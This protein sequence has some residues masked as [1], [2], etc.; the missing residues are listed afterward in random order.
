MKNNRG[1][2]LIELLVAFFAFSVIALAMSTTAVS[3]IKA[4]RRAFA[5]Q[6][7]QEDSRYII[8]TMGKE[9]R[10]GLV[11]SL[12]G[13]GVSSINITNSDGES[14]DYRFVFNKLQ[15]RVDGGIWQ[16]LNSTD[17]FHLNGSFYITKGV[18]PVRAI[19]TIAIK[20]DCQSVKAEEQATIYLQ[21]TIAPRI[22]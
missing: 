17:Y 16:D 18:S 7:I 19:V 3:T 10:M 20:L 6:S 1:F 12:S 2:T 5:L 13:A 22:Y 9:I 11:N 8:E 14:I 15:R 4:Q 21:N